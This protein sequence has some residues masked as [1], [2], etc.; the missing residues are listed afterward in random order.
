MLNWKT[1]EF[2][3]RNPDIAVKDLGAGLREGQISLML[4]AGCSLP[5]KLPSWPDLVRQCCEQISVVSSGGVDSKDIDANWSGEKL[6]M[7]MSRARKVLDDDRRYIEIIG[8]NLYREW[9]LSPPTE[10]T[11]LLRAIGT[12][13][14]GSERGRVRDILT[15]NFDSLLEWY[16]SFHGYVVQI[17]EHVPK[18]LRRSDVTMYHPHGYLPFDN[19]LGRPS[20]EVI[21]DQ[22]SVERRILANQNAWNE[23]FRHFLGSHVFIAI[24]LSGNDFLQRLLLKAAADQQRDDRPLGFWFYRKNADP[25][26]IDDLRGKSV[27]MLLIENYAQIEDFLFGICREAAGRVLI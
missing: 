5:M 8:E 10:F 22:E 17:V 9:R 21:F 3:E 16:L 7:R 25:D 15:F 18:I 2:Y 11:P 13:T 6:L 24:G 27:A 14:I 26:V 23:T 19:S 1:P 4:G 20:E 12:M